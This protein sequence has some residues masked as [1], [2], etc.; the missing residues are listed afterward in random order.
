MRYAL[1]EQTSDQPYTWPDGTKLWPDGTSTF[2]D[3]TAYWPDGTTL[4]P[5]GTTTFPNSPLDTHPQKIGPWTTPYGIN[6]DGSA[7]ITQPWLA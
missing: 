6:P 2:P 3:G 5:D 4:W 1:N 7:I